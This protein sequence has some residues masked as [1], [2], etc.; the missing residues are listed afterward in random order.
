LD[1]NKIISMIRNIYRLKYIV[2]LARHLGNY[3]KTGTKL[4]FRFMY[5]ARPIVVS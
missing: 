4:L 5:F 1:T 3:I 2:F